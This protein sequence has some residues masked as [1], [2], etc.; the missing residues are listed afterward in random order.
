MNL[1]TGIPFLTVFVQG[2]LSFFS[3]CILPL[4]PLYIG[5]LAGGTS[6]VDE[7]GMI[8][9]PRKKVM[10]NTVFFVLGIGFAFILL[11][12]GF[13]AVGRF[14]SGQREWFTRIGGVIMIFFGVYQMGLL[15]KTGVM[16]KEH[17]VS[18][19]LNKRAMG[20]W[21]ALLFGFTFSFAWTPC[22]GPVLASVLLMASSAES[23]LSG[24]LLIGVYL[25]GFVLPFLAVGLFTGAVL[26]FFKKHQQV[27]KYT[28]KIG[29]A[30]LILMGIM[31]LT[32]WMN[33][34]TSY[35]SS[36][37]P[38]QKSTSEEAA[39]APKSENAETPAAETT[40]EKEKKEYPEAPNFELKDRYGKSHLLSDYKG[41]T[42]FL[43]FWATWCGPCRKE[44]PDIQ[45]LYEEY[46]SNEGEL[47][48]LGVVNPKTEEHPKNSDVTQSE[49]EAF[50]DENEY[51]YPALMDTTGDVFYQ[52]GISAFPTTFMID[53]EGRVKGY[54]AGALTEE[55]MKNMIS[56][57]MNE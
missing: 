41:K 25:L 39:K 2:I 31:T 9:Y 40:K 5:Y 24:F 44:M 47:I 15:G 16:G 56:Q 6:T 43:N 32:G 51:S 29:G 45:R 11:G 57:T 34:I 21:M 20:P 23:S 10:L 36:Y 49:V 22:V 13:S 53:K 38:E 12:F 14:F 46:G 3:P 27:I 28:V 33:G 8:I 30:L 4:V 1:E 19:D 35:L 52:Y 54:V 48:I 26:E 18:I 50:L 37:A 7:N 55:Q 17:R 42:V